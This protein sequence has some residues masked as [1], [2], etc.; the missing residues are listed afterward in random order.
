MSVSKKKEE[1]KVD[2]KKSTKKDLKTTASKIT[3]K[4]SK[5]VLPKSSIKE[6]S[7][8]N[9]LNIDKD[10]REKLFLMS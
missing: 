4:D 8:K 7:K 9:I 5:S 1:D 6:N 10:S 2:N 3:S